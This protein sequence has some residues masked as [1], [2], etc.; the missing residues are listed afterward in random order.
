[1]GTLVKGGGYKSEM[2]FGI[3]FL[4]GKQDGVLPQ[5]NSDGGRSSSNFRT[6][7]SLSYYLQNHARQ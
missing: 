2:I 7:F 6:D 1:M 3:R 4:I 5:I